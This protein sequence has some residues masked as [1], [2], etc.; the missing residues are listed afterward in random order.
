[1]VVTND[2]WYGEEGAAS[3]HA[4]HSVLR[5]VETRRPVVRC[6]N[7]GWSGWIDEFG[8]I[9][10]Y[11]LTNSE[12]SVAFRGTGT[13]NVTRDSRWAGRESFYVA[14]GDWLVPA[15]AILAV[16]AYWLLALA[17]RAPRQSGR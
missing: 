16:L 6:G 9:I 7:A 1:M 14:H 2:A 13:C 8:G 17:S 10:R 3:Q 4:A 15:C 11:E 12:G 5:A